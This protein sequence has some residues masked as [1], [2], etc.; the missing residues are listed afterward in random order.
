MA[1]PRNSSDTGFAYPASVRRRAVIWTTSVVSPGTYVS[2]YET[3]NSSPR[4]GNWSPWSHPLPHDERLIDGYVSVELGDACG[5]TDGQQVFIVN[6][7]ASAAIRVKLQ[8]SFSENGQTRSSVRMALLRPGERD[9]VGCSMQRI[10][11]GEVRKFEWTILD[12]SFAE[13]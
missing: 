5:N 12:A 3:K 7:H 8:R 13:R 10:G 11:A 1:R 6:S 4:N 2:S 9:N